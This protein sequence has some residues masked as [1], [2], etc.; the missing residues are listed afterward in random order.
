[1]EYARR[2]LFGGECRH[3]VRDALLAAEAGL[4]WFPPPS[5]DEEPGRVFEW[6]ARALYVS[7]IAEAYASRRARR[8][9]A[10]RGLFTRRIVERLL[11]DYWLSGG[12]RLLVTDVRAS[13]GWIAIPKLASCEEGEPE[14][15]F[16]V[17]GD[18]V[19]R[20]RSVCGS[21]SL[22]ARVEPP[23]AARLRVESL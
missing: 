19:L 11:H 22:E 17:D 1:L 14:T 2:G 20:V 18:G 5:L 10:S 7:S 8:L 15:T 4:A 23:L 21:R 16:E 9:V 12:V 3:S 13:I 6:A